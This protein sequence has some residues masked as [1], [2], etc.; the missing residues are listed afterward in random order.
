VDFE[1]DETGRILSSSIVQGSGDAAFDEAA[2]AMIRRS[3]PVPPPPVAVAQEGLNFTL[4]IIFRA[5]H[6]G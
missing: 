3:D 4:P 1:L 2:L 5:R 6:G